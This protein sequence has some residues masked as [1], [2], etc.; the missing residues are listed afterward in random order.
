M[1]SIMYALIA[2]LWT[3]MTCLEIKNKNASLAALDG[4]CAGLNLAIFIALLGV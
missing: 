4:A 2:G 3:V 1:S